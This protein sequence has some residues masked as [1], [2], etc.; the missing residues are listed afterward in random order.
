MFLLKVRIFLHKKMG[1]GDNVFLF[2]PNLIGYARVILM[3]ASFFFAFHRFEVFLGLYW[4]SFLLD[5]AD[6][7]AARLLGQ[8][9]KF[10]A[11]LDMVTDR[12][13]TNALVIIL[14]HLYPS[15][16]AAF[17]LLCT[18]DLGSHWIR[19]YSSLLTGAKSHKD[20]GVN[21][22]FIVSLYYNNRIVLGTVCLMNE[23]FYVALYCL[24]FMPTVTAVRWAVYVA[25][26]FFALKQYI[27][28]VQLINSSII[29]VEHDKAERAGKK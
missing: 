3:I 27:S 14:S 6:G 15:H 8:S 29:V 1:G 22:G 9:S 24:H 16:V 19:M 23:A 18:L 10:G 7:H 12:V 5:A 11:V 21:D 26:P 25:A 4:L 20:T 13:A 17:M 28:T 2:V